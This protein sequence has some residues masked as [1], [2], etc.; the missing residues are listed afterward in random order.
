VGIPLCPVVLC[1]ENQLE[2]HSLTFFNVEEIQDAV[3]LNNL[4]KIIAR[5]SFKT[6]NLAYINDEIN[7]FNDI[8]NQVHQKNLYQKC[9]N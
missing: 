4:T 7:H 8:F 2:C 5:E 6:K 3:K 1:Y 9:F